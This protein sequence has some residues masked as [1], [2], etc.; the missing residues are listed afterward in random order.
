MESR[1]R[2]G[3][4]KSS[5]TIRGIGARDDSSAGRRSG[6][7]AAHG[8]R[9]LDER[10]TQY[11]A[12]RLRQ[13]LRLFDG[14]QNDWAVSAKRHR[15]PVSTRWREQQELPVG[16]VLVIGRGEPERRGP[17]KCET[18]TTERVRQADSERLDVRLFQGP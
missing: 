2:L 3:D 17:L 18:K 5:G 7:P 10:R 16:S 12:V 8:R 4:R 9:L 6:D 14:L 13:S 1:K 11:R 15:H